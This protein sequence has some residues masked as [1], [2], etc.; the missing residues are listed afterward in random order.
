MSLPFTGGG[1]RCG[2]C[3][4]Y[5]SSPIPGQGW[6]THPELVK[7]PA[8]VLVKARELN[9]AR[10]LAEVPDRWEPAD[11]RLTAAPPPPLR[12]RTLPVASTA[13]LA[14]SR[15][16]PPGDAAGEPGP[17]AELGGTAPMPAIDET[18][19]FEPE[20]GPATAGERSPLGTPVP[21]AAPEPANR[22]LLWLVLVPVALCLVLALAGGVGL[23]VTGGFGSGLLQLATPTPTRPAG[24]PAVAL[25]DFRLQSEP[26]MESQPRSVVRQGTRLLLINSAGG[27]ILDPALPEPSKWYLVRTADGTAEGWAYSGWV[28]R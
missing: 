9:C 22:R 18:T 5:R 16:I 12:P 10:P 2:T 17:V 15:P 19:P 6:C 7:P 4:Y 3:R 23:M 28:Q 8:M 14:A 11:P 20:E 21:P 25:R 27:E 26:R 1:R 24:I 13:P